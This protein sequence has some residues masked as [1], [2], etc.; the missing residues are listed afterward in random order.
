MASIMEDVC[1]QCEL[2]AVKQELNDLA[3]HKLTVTKRFDQCHYTRIKIDALQPTN[4]DVE[5]YIQV[6]L[7]PIASLRNIMNGIVAQD[8]NYEDDL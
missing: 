1:L 2:N 8:V 5:L 3:Y 7:S 6:H 4:I